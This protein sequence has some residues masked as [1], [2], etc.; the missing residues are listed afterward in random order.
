[1]LW[2]RVPTDAHPNR[3]GG[4]RKRAATRARAPGRPG[5]DRARRCAGADREGAVRAGAHAG[6]AAHARVRSAREGAVGD[7]VLAS[8]LFRASLEVGR[9]GR[10]RSPERDG[11][12]CHRQPQLG[13]G[14]LLQRDAPRER[15]H[16]ALGQYAARRVHL[17]RHGVRHDECGR[18]DG[19]RDHAGQP[20]RT[21]RASRRS[22]ACSSPTA[23]PS[24]ATSAWAR[25]AAPRSCSSIPWTAAETRSSRRAGRSQ[26]P[27]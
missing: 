22:R 4:R 24:G 26:S 3:Y 17:R 1:M 7:A 2:E 23:R 15:G 18:R 14:P 19:E 8:R 9:E 16:G 12:R 11:Q 13:E 5:A 25:R 27:R 20:R 6:V 21:L 10:R